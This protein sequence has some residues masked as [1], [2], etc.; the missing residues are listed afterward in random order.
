MTYA[1]LIGGILLLYLGADLLVCASIQMAHR[2]RIS[3]F[4]SGLTV[5]AFATSI[6]EAV[7]SF[8]A[9]VHATSDIALGNV[10]GSNIANIGLV[11]GI[12]LLMTTCL[13]QSVKRQL[14]L[15]IL[16]TFVIWLLMY[17]GPIHKLAGAGLLICL[18]IYTYMQYRK[19]HT[20]V[21]SAPI[22]RWNRFW[23]LFPLVTIASI[24]VLYLGAYF[25]VHG[26]VSIAEKLGIS[27]RVIAISVVAVG[28]SLPELATAIVAATK[29]QGELILGNVIGSN[30]FNLL[31]IIPIASFVREVDF[32][33]EMFVYDAPT[34]M[35]FTLAL[36]GLIMIR[37]RLRAIDGAIF[38]VLYVGYVITLYLL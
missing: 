13:T 28:T 11:L 18:I 21:Y 31:F 30:I 15:L 6:P 23:L 8:I 7:T 35:F 33:R 34:M 27:H 25:L 22:T 24:A 12:A 17:L 4:L 1:F 3:T 14:G 20:F 9:Q 19:R 2:F 26:A 32:T 37:K 36:A 38:L 10:I 5:V 16:F 29:K